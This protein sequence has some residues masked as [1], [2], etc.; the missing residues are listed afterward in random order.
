MHLLKYFMILIFVTGFN[1]SAQIGVRKSFQLGM[2]SNSAGQTFLGNG[3]VDL[4]SGKNSIWAAT[5]YGLNASYDQGKS[6]KIFTSNEYKGKGGVSAIGF[7]DDSTLWIATA[8]DTTAQGEDLSAGGGL[9]YTR[10]GGLTW[11]HIKQPV[12]S[13]DVSEYS[14]TTTVVQNLTFDFAFIDSTIWI[15]SYGGGLRRSDDMGQSWQVVTTDGHPFSSFDYLSHRG[16]SLLAENGNLWYGSAEGISKSTDNGQTWQRFMHANQEYPISG[17]FVVAL[18]YQEATHTVWAATVE[19]VNEGEVRAVSKTTNGGLT[20]QVVL[21]GIF[22]HNFGFDDESVFV[23]ADEGLF[24]SEDSGENW[25]K[26]PPV[27]DSQSG[28]EIL[29]NEFYSAA[30]Q[31]SGNTSRWWLGSSDGLATTTDRGNTWQVVRSFVST[32]ERTKPKVYAYPSPF[33]PSRSGYTRFQYNVDDGSGRVLDTN[34]DIEIKIYNFAME[35]V[36][37]IRD[38]KTGFRSETGD[39][40]TKWDGKDSVGKLVASGVYFF[41]ARIGNEVSWGKVVV[42]N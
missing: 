15:A 1:L 7:M 6:W 32:R 9:S 16:F 36:V 41:R 19:A 39:F 20:W 18:A 27:V 10:D 14:P 34:D 35:H 42:I 38:D 26:A 11:T 21:K 17:N 37:T 22:A 23:A 31:V 24:I 12:D 40:S 5:G 13:R 8:F 30:S 29:S 3:V 25:Y 33:S 4:L 28:E 2:E